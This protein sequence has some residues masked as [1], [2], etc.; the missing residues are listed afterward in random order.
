MR[1]VHCNAWECSGGAARA[2]RRLHRGLV[3]HAELGVE[4]RMLVRHRESE[5]PAVEAVA[6]DP[7]DET[8]WRNIEHHWIAGN[9]TARSN[10][11]FST[12][13]PGS[14]IAEHPRIVEADV[15]HLH[16]IPGL[17]ASGDVVRLLESGKPIVWT[18]HDEWAFT[19]GCHY[20]AGCE[21]WRE[22]CTA[23]PQLASDRLG[24]VD[25]MF[26]DKRAFGRI[27]RLEVVAPSRWLGER[28]ARSAIL[29]R[30]ASRTIPYGIELDVF[31]P[32]GRAAARAR[33]GAAEGDALLLFAASDARERR[34]GFGELLSAL[35]RCREDPRV[36][37]RFEAGRVVAVTLGWNDDRSLPIPFRALGHVD[38]DAA[39]AAAISACDLYVIPSL[40]DNLPNGAIEALAC[41]TPVAGFAAGGIPEIVQGQPL[42][43]LAPVGDT[44]GLADRIALAISDLDRLRALR[45]W[46]RQTALER[47]SLRG[48]A[49]AY[50]SLYRGLVASAV[51]GSR[52]P[53]TEHSR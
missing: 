25:A 48:Q 45:G 23:C 41:G 11:W 24:L 40:E 3:R 29:G 19:G 34:K 12:G 33:L 10:T 1:V 9:R 16:W 13:R 47:F 51:E 31:A 14:S 27:G 26:E 7:V 38:D 21:R 18:L 5:D 44:A 4:S 46:A 22:R 42:E 35:E 20:T 52:Q 49:A 32:E 36:A 15:V 53:T 28:A 6:V 37:A 50:A 43:L 39:L 8:R 2:A 17:V 30:R